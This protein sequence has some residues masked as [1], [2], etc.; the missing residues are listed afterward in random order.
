MSKKSTDTSKF[1][2]YV[3]RHEPEAIELSLDK[4]GWAVIDDLILRAGNKG[5]ALDKDLIFD[6]VESS[7]KKRFTIS[8]DGLR[9]RAA[10]GHSTQ[11]VNI[12]YVEKMP[13]DI[14]YHGTATRFIVQIRD[15]G[16][17]PLSRQYVHLSSDEDTAIQVGQRYGKPVLLK[18]KAVD[19]YEKGYKF[20]QADNGV[21]LTAHVPYEYI[22]E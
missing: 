19:M 2:S 7:E 14:L 3:L 17:L 9:I 15:Q 12:T 6:V 8:E 1:L 11:Q 13:P 21:W 5:Y 20:Y 4:E 10:Q 22:Q 16:L 18:I